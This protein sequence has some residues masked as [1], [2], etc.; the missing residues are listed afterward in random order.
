MRPLAQYR[1]PAEAGLGAFENRL[2]GRVCV[3][4]YFPWTFL[5]NLSKS[6]QIK[7]ILRWLSKDALPGWVASF[8][9]AHL[10]V[11]APRPGTLAAVV[12][13]TSLD[14]AESLRL[15]LRTERERLTVLDMACRETRV[16]ASGADGPYREFVLPRVPPWGLVLAIAGEG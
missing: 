12:I 13:N 14:P 3:A 9:K 11:L 6:S 15:K 4:G 5:Q 16:Q 1:D 7:A 8:H 10:W 2:G